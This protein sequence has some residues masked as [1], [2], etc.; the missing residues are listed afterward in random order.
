MSDKKTDSPI[1]SCGFN[2][3]V[4]SRYGHM[5]YNPNDI[6]IGKSFEQYGEY[7][8]GE[9]ALFRQILPPK[10]VILDIGAHIGSHTLFF[11]RAAGPEGAVLAFEP[12][13]IIFQTL[14]ANIALN[15]LQ[16]VHCYHAAV[17]D[18]PGSINVPA[19]DYQSENNFAGLSLGKYGHGEKTTVM[20]IDSLDLQQCFFMK[21]DVEGMELAALK[22][23]RKTITKFHPILYI[24]ND[25]K[26][27][28]PGLISYIDSLGY[29]MYWHLPPL[30]NKNNYL[31]NTHNLFKN[32][33]SVNMLCIHSSMNIRF[34]G[35]KE[36]SGPEDWFETGVKNEK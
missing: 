2:R 34:E 35:L 30:F 25:R 17:S 26:D 4:R 29:K 36:V 9:I 14:C 13:R 33:V 10:A 23:A 32:I 28:A 6:Y 18:I 21:I 15:G 5:L 22:G 19:F 27:N 8:E 7:S 31:N 20:T 12:Q 11:S 1:L 16:N 3:L 24:E